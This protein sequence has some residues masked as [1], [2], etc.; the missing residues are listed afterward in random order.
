MAFAVLA[1]G[2][3]EGV[4]PER[5]E[6]HLRLLAEA[7]L[8]GVITSGSRAG[9]PGE[10][11]SPRLL[12]VARA[13]TGVGA[14]DTGTAD[15]VLA[16]FDMAVAIRETGPRR[17][18]IEL[19][20]AIRRRMARLTRAAAGPGP[21]APG[22]GADDRVV[23][24]GM[25]I[26]VRDDDVRGELYL[27]AFS[28]TASGARFSVYARLRG[29]S[30]LGSTGYPAGGHL[31]HDL[32]ATDEAG[33]RYTMSF[34]GSI[35]TAGW[36]GALRLQPGPPPGVRWLDVTA[37]GAAER[38]VSLGSPAYRPAV[39]VTEISR[40][41]GECLLDAY[42]VRILV[43]AASGPPYAPR[44]D[45]AALTAW[46]GDVVEALYA[47]AALSPLSPVPGQL[48]TLCES[49]NL[50]AHGIAAAPVHELP[51]TW[52]SLLTHAHRRKPDISQ[53]RDGCAG[54]AVAL[55]G[56]DGT[57]LAIMGLHG[58]ERGTVL[59]V[60]VTGMPV[61][62]GQ[63]ER[64]LPPLW[65]RDDAGR[66]HATHSTAGRG[67]AGND[68]IALLEVVPP[69]SGTTSVELLAAGRSAEVRTTLPVRWR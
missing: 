23:P 41:P 44:R 55:P 35:S 66:W 22:P 6:V 25:M 68:G 52:L 47:A 3:N 15:S 30:P 62:A 50:R 20:P 39:T 57:T 33:T 4:N 5:A 2:E 8:R 38:R 54:L 67:G 7:E 17:V 56:L 61:V 31:L 14:L 21:A 19:R 28:Q 36:A 24:V 18:Q 26:P 40:S 46:L 1:L 11:G 48:A 9:L 29:T 10:S 53:P 12:R 13:L 60:Q 42:A 51:K 58:D 64:L 45:G 16:G 34:N 63:D 27:L 69:L 59:H 32:T 49:L 65:L 37:P 43:A